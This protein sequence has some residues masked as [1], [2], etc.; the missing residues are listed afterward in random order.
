[1]SG[2]F[3]DKIHCSVLPLFCKNIKCFLE[4]SVK[5]KTSS[6]FWC[7]QPMYLALWQILNFNFLRNKHL[8]TC[9]FWYYGAFGIQDIWATGWV[10][11]FLTIFLHLCAV[12][13]VPPFVR[14]FTSFPLHLHFN[15]G[16]LAWSHLLLAYFSYAFFSIYLSQCSTSLEPLSWQHSQPLCTT[17]FPPLPLHRLLSFNTQRPTEVTSGPELWF[18]TKS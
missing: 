9:G 18:I 6:M 10:L 17:L 5:I 1:M 2:F 3:N 13:I 12:Y 7:N 4:L 11:T 8:T 16:F 15:S 14:I